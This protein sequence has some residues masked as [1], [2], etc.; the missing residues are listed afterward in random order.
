MLV[1]LQCD[2]LAELEWLS[3]FVEESFS[4]VDTAHPAA[5]TV[6]ALEGPRGVTTSEVELAEEEEEE[7]EE[8]EEEE[9]TSKR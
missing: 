9:K 3:N 4:S 7:E 8:Q 1:P 5:S 2:E 6:P